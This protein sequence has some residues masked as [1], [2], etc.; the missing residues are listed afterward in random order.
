MK[1]DQLQ[2][3]DSLVPRPKGLLI[4]SALVAA[5]LLY[6]ASRSTGL[7]DHYRE[8]HDIYGIQPSG[9][10]QFVLNA[11]NFWLVLSVP[12]MLLF[13]WI[14]M[15]SEVTPRELKRMKLAFTASL[16][17]DGLVYGLVAYALLGPLASLGKTV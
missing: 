5:F 10:T 1:R 7:L 17:L 4:A 15:K 14:A 9:L 12:A 8:M 13:G 2:P 6:A 16:L 3:V 11:P